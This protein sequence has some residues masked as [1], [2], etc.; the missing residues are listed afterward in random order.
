MPMRAK[1]L[2]IYVRELV[3]TRIPLTAILL[4]FGEN[5]ILTAYPSKSGGDWW[6]GTLVKDG[7]SGFFPNTYVQEL[8]HGAYLYLS[9]SC[10]SHSS[11][12]YSSS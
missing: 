8:E 2:R 10:L 12:S 11:T 6:Y 9:R 5:L 1:G 7:K 3:E 4:A